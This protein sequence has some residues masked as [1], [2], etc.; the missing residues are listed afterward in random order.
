VSFCSPALP[1]TGGKRRRGKTPSRRAA[2]EGKL[3]AFGSGRAGASFTIAE[4]NL[5]NGKY[6]SENEFEFG[7]NLNI[8]HF[9]K[10]AI[11]PPN[12][13]FSSGKIRGHPP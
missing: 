10:K 13:Y 8:I 3:Q 4:E 1:E 2:K 12:I 6:K 5:E 9:I 7:F 11:P